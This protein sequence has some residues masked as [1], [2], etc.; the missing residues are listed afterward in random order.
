LKGG[1]L[2]ICG[3]GTFTLKGNYSSGTLIINSGAT[4]NLTETK[5]NAN[6]S[7][8]IINRG[9]LNYQTTM[10]NN[11][12]I[13]NFGTLKIDGDL[14]INGILDN[15]GFIEVSGFLKSMGNTRITLAEKSVMNVNSISNLNTQ[16]L[17]C[18]GCF[19]S[20][21][22]ILSAPTGELTPTSNNIFVYSLNGF[23]TP[24]FSINTDG[25]GKSGGATLQSGCDC[26]P[27]IT[28]E[29]DH[30][31][32]KGN[33]ATLTATVKYPGNYTYRWSGGGVNFTQA[34]I[35]VNPQETTTYTVV[36]SNGA[37]QAS[38]TVTVTVLKA[39]ITQQPDNNDIKLTATQAGS[40]LWSTGETDQSIIIR[41]TPKATYSVTITKDKVSCTVGSI[42]G[43]DSIPDCGKPNHNLPEVVDICEKGKSALLNAFVEGATY[44][45]S[46]GARTSSIEVSPTV[47]TS[48]RVTIT[49]WCGTSVTENVLVRTLEDTGV[50]L[51]NENKTVN[52]CAN[53]SIKL[54]AT[55]GVSY[56]WS[57]PD[58]YLSNADSAVTIIRPKSSTTYSVAIKTAG[59]CTVYKETRVNVSTSFQ[60]KVDR[61]DIY[62]CKGVDVTLNASGADDYRWSPKDGLSCN[63]CSD[64]VHNVIGNRTFK[65]TGT[66]NGCYMEETVNIHQHPDK[67]NFK[68]TKNGCFVSFEAIDDKNEFNE[69][70]WDLGDKK[71]GVFGEKKVTRQYDGNGDYYV[72][73]KA[74]NIICGKTAYRR[75]MITITQEECPCQLP[76]CK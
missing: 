36:V 18:G 11:G 54:T 65:V 12:S 26:K 51:S 24:P 1:T 4:V 53:D 2:I 55:G 50:G 40:Y 13:L 17:G 72:S 64:P 21:G 41:S 23:G 45:W 27:Q 47:S 30:T 22:K 70:E 46:T 25:S 14:N 15:G 76:E 75:V 63:D 3:S 49:A 9:T 42:V 61:K 48:Y 73:L 34:T 8:S 33:T 74:K 29:G 66:K 69:Y 6:S 38:A 19:Y 16:L 32:C 68:V 71:A 7:V 44:Q 59:G 56:H 5:P 43:Y 52:V 20:A 67:I 60:L 35:T 57:P 28:I 37:Q 62:A 31:I 10:N 39:E 58:D